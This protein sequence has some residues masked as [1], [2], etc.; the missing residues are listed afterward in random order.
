ME[1]VNGAAGGQ[2][3]SN[4]FFLKLTNTGMGSRADIVMLGN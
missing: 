2:A 3:K 4:A 1:L